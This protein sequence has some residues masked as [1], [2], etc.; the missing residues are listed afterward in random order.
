MCQPLNCVLDHPFTS[1]NS[2]SYSAPRCQI[3]GDQCFDGHCSLQVLYSDNANSSVRVN[4]FPAP[5]ERLMTANC[6]RLTSINNYAE[7]GVVHVVDRMIRPVTKTL[8]DLLAQDSQ[9]SV[10]RTCKL[11]LLSCLQYQL[12]SVLFFD[13]ICCE[14]KF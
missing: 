13:K 6:A 4:I 5:G 7:N 12:Q 14:I 1:L 10:L 3:L 11:L 8:A 9:F 2:A